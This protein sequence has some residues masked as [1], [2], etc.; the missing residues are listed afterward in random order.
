M[1][2]SGPGVEG[3]SSYR[4]M[5]PSHKPT[6]N[7]SS[8]P[9]LQ[10]Q[11]QPCPAVLP[12]IA[13]LAKAV[14]EQ[15]A[16]AKDAP[17]LFAAASN[18]LRS[19][20]GQLQHGCAP[21]LYLRWLQPSL[22]GKASRSGLQHQKCG[23]PSTEHT[24]TCRVRANS[25][26]C[27]ACLHLGHRSLCDEERAGGAQ[28]RHLGAG[29][30]VARLSERCDIGGEEGD[31]CAGA[32]GTALHGG[33]WGDVGA[34]GAADGCSGTVRAGGTGQ[35]SEVHGVC[36]SGTQHAQSVTSKGKSGAAAAHM[37]RPNSEL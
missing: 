10:P 18:L 31:G 17:L 35:R 24:G 15:S 6:H 19:Q 12:T 23:W 1:Q 28:R 3:V 7:R 16:R 34:G 21:H 11:P 29:T 25:K 20:K 14:G 9:Q 4:K 36:S 26:H 2:K 32:D 22:T 8:C 30:L 33:R 27:A 5:K 13:E 37:Q